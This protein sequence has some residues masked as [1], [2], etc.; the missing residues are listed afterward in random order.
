MAASRGPRPRSLTG[1][2]ACAPAGLPSGR[3]PG[4]AEC[5]PCL[6][7]C[8]LNVSCGYVLSHL[9]PFP[10]GPPDRRGQGPWASPRPAPA[11]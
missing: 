4:P 7:P 9:P 11:H 3:P 10:A 8:P 1:P 6:G 2:F 5:S